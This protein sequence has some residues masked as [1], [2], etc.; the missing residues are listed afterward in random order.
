MHRSYYSETISN[1]L[2]EESSSIL[3][4]LNAAHALENL[5]IKQ[6]RAWESQIII[7]KANLQH[8]D[9]GR[10]IFEFSIPRMGKRADNIIVLGDHLIVFEFKTGV[11]SY[12]SGSIAQAIDYSLD[13][14]NF[15][16]SSHDK[17][18]VPVLVATE[19]PI[20]EC[21]LSST[22]NLYSP[23]LCNAENLS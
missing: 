1:F 21:N 2:K 7:L 14:L 8:V 20:V 9:S 4:K 19:A 23:I 10:I 16:E 6:T 11:D 13:L 15:H 18:V 12:D 17:K 3:R 5:N 22:E